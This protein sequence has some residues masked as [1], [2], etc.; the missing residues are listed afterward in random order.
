MRG[1]GENDLKT[2]SVEERL[3]ERKSIGHLGSVVVERFIGCGR[4]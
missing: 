1:D 2:T 4:T 3:R